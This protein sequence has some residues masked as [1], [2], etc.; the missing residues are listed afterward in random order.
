[1]VIWLP[2]VYLFTHADWAKPRGADRQTYRQMDHATAKLIRTRHVGLPSLSTDLTMELLKWCLIHTVI[3]C[4]C[5][6][7]TNVWPQH[8]TMPNVSINSSGHS[9]QLPV[10]MGVMPLKV[11]VYAYMYVRAV[12]L[13]SKF[14]SLYTQVIVRMETS[15]CTVLYGTCAL[16]DEA[17]CACV[18]ILFNDA[19]PEQRRWAFTFI[20]I[21]A[22]TDITFNAGDSC[23]HGKV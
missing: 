19:I 5:K 22:G 7:S 23:G 4:Q 15:M 6:C 1:M 17:N 3:E 13:S 8:C 2:N 18:Y 12:R 21:Y 16:T 10:A 9:R 11:S 14:K 20:F